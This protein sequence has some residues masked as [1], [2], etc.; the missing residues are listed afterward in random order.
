MSSFFESL[1]YGVIS[2]SV[3]H[4][5]GR[6]VTTEL[7]GPPIILVSIEVL[8]EENFD[9]YPLGD[10]SFV[11]GQHRAIPVFPINRYQY[12]RGNLVCRVE[13]WSWK[14]GLE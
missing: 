7:K 13:E 3:S 11:L 1:Q 14:T 2:S 12:E 5:N 4:E 10:G 8:A 6:K 9:I